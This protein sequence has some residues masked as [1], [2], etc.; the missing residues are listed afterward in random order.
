MCYVF[1]MNN[2]QGGA[3]MFG[4]LRTLMQGT[5]ARAE[6]RVRA[7]FAIELIDQKIREGSE[8]L[9]LAKTTLASLIQRQRNEERQI[10]ALSARA[11]DLMGRAR[12]ALESGR[13]DLA[14]EAAE[15]IAVMENELTLRRETQCRLEG[16]VMR[17]QTSVE[18]A[19]RRLIDLKQGAIA[20]RAVRDEQALQ[21]RMNTTLSGIS[22]MAEAEAL[23]AEVLGRDDPYE[24][25]E[26]LAE[27]DRGL[28]RET[29]ADKLADQGFGSA[30]KSTTADV[31]ARLKAQ[32]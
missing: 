3:Q 29:I 26:I 15:A 5:N 17:M 31:L 18:T 11:T 22:P 23:I 25:S 10:A 7:A 2:V 21:M 6:E 24:Q 19:T 28:N 8:G 12:E 9:R 20:A 32:G 14:T 27:I 30:L 13:E 1:L 16:R 4:T